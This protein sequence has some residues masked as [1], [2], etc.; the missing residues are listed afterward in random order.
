MRTPESDDVIDELAHGEGVLATF[1]LMLWCRGTGKRAH[2]LCGVHIPDTIV[3]LYSKPLHWFFSSKTG[4]IRRKSRS[5]LNSKHIEEQFTKHGKS[6]SGVKACYLT[7]AA[8]AGPGAVVKATYTFG[9]D[10]R[11]FLQEDKP[12]GVLQLFFDPKPEVSHDGACVRN[13]VVQ[14]NWS[15][16]CFFIEKRVNKHR[17]D[18]SKVPID[19]RAAT[20]GDHLNTETVPLVSST[21]AAAFQ[22]TC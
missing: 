14:A 6:L 3:Y 4:D 18:A 11:K 9:K 21:V 5:R 17:L 15:P 19:A 16:G 2:Q 10:L 12:N 8:A 1:F 7:P 13:S 20:H 22:R